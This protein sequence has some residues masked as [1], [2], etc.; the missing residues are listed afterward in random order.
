MFADRSILHARSCNYCLS[1]WTPSFCFPVYKRRSNQPCF[2]VLFL[3]FADQISY[4][5]SDIL[6]I[7]RISAVFSFAL[8]GIIVFH[9]V[10]N[11]H[12]FM[13]SATIWPAAMKNLNLFSSTREGREEVVKRYFNYVD[14]LNDWQR[15][16]NF[17]VLFWNIS[18]ERA[19]FNFKNGSAFIAKA[20]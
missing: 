6:Q 17:H 5:W 10:S 1:V 8:P 16:N 18:F 14:L 12:L 13:V 11:L 15:L 19:F 4:K 9:V 3:F 2:I 7:P 20:L